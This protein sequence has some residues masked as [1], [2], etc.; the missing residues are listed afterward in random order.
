MLYNSKINEQVFWYNF[1]NYLGFFLSFTASITI[2]PEDLTF[3]GEVRFIETLGHFIFPLILFGLPQALIRF[4]PMML[5]YHLPRFY[6]TSIFIILFTSS[7]VFLIL[8]LSNFV[9]KIDNFDLYIY[10][11]IL[12]CCYSFIDLNKSISIIF[13]KVKFPVFIE[14]ILPKIFFP[15]IFILFLSKYIDKK[16]SLKYFILIH[17]LIVI[18]LFIFQF[19]FITP[20]FSKKYYFLFEKFSV[21]E[22]VNFSFFSFLSSIGFLLV[23]RIDSYMI[24]LFL[25]ME[26]NGIFSV[27]LTISS[28]IGIPM[29]GY[30]LL[31]SHMISQL[32]E[33]KNYSELS[34]NYKESAKYLYWIGSMLFCL[35]LI[36]LSSLNDFL[37][38]PIQL[39]EIKIITILLSISVLINMGTSY[40]TEIINYSKYYKFNLVS[41]AILVVINIF[42]NLYFLKFTDY[43]LVGIAFSSMFSMLIFNVVKITFI[44]NKMKITPFDKKYLFIF[45]ISIFLYLLIYVLPNID[46]LIFNI[47]Y[48]TF[49]IS[50]LYT[51]LIL[52]FKLIKFSD[53]TLIKYPFISRFI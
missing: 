51:F 29:I 53:D 22:F 36:I 21:K 1:V 42:F 41:L 4:S 27:A 24:P 50:L 23:Y 6:G 40:N 7:L 8:N 26:D 10:G 37:N 13:K 38:N 17:I 34:F 31:N 18:V 33:E 20:K 19:R 2:F 16:E 45:L 9:I 49:L 14:K 30:F 52:K 28:I 32:I 15:I 48:K 44:Y 35:I 46:S 47:L 12:A 43:K 39:S 3:L 11:F 25:T 5:S